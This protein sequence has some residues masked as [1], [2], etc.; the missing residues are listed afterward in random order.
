MIEADENDSGE[1]ENGGGDE[2]EHIAEVE[3]PLVPGGPLAPGPQ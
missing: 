1:Y 3:E 2:Q